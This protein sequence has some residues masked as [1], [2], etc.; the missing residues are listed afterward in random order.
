MSQLDVKKFNRILNIYVQLQS[1]NWITAQQ[2]AHRYDVSIRTIYRD[3]KALENAGVPIYNEPGKGYA[4]VEGYKIPPTIFTKEEALSFTIAEK[5]VEKFADKK[6]SFN[7]SAALHK[8]KAVLRTSEKENVALIEDQYLIFN[9]SSTENTTEVLS[10]LLDSIVSKIQIEILYQKPSSNQADKRL[11][12][13]IGIFYENEYWYFMAFCYLRNDYR[14]FRIDRVKQ[15]VK[16]NH[17]FNKEHKA[18]GYF[19]DKKKSAESEKI[20]VKILAPK[21]RAHYFNWDKN[22]Y[23]FVSEKEINDSVEMT[24][25]TT[26]KLEYFARW[27]LMYSIEAE[28][29]E[30]IELKQKV[31]DLLQKALDKIEKESSVHEKKQ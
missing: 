5:L 23:G 2:F 19:L 3:I 15:I 24:F 28:I 21:N 27:F 20:T 10:V 13:P 22:S 7:F 18:L 30:P 14:Q 16:T 29:V 9:S 12:E 1:R 26:T 25:E 17:L 11:L 4:L 8:M 6:M 31:T